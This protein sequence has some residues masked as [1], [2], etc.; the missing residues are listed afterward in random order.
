MINLGSEKTTTYTEGHLTVLD[1]PSWTI[2]L[3]QHTKGNYIAGRRVNTADLE[4]QTGISMYVVDQSAEVMKFSSDTE[5]LNLMDA[6]GYE[7]EKSDT[8]GN[9]WEYTFKKKD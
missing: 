7:M 9:G 8:L 1:A 6:A 2:E 5:F 3:Q 4:S